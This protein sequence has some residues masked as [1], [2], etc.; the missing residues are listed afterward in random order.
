MVISNCKYAIA[1]S[2]FVRCY[3]A[4]VDDGFDVIV[5]EAPLMTNFMGSILS[6]REYSYWYNLFYDIFKP[7]KLRAVRAF[8]YVVCVL[9]FMCECGYTCTI[10]IA[11]SNYLLVLANIFLT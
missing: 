1:Y 10:M 7:I 11:K 8:L 4:C 9:M 5:I 2:I 3:N 6:Q